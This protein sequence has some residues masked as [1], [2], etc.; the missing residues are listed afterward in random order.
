MN[1]Q[2][3]YKKT[4]NSNEYSKATKRESNYITDKQPIDLLKV[5][6]GKAY[7]IANGLPP[8]K[9]ANAKITY[10]KQAEKTPEINE[11]GKADYFDMNFIVEIKEGSWLGEKIPAQEG[12]EGINILGEK[13]PASNR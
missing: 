6:T 4:R 3:L 12:I 1:L 10:L 2:S 11:D 5:K 8:Q 7:I 9:G 13:V